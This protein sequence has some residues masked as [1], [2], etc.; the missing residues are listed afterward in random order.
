MGEGALQL[1]LR[2]TPGWVGKP[3]WRADACGEGR[4]V[5]GGHSD[6]NLWENRGITRCHSSNPQMSELERSLEST[7]FRQTSPFTDGVSEAQGRVGRDE[8]DTP[9][10]GRLGIRTHLS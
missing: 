10:R 1:N 9:R 2:K 6:A 3:H 7:F 8:V 4:E 5:L